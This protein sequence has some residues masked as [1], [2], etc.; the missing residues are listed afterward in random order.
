VISEGELGCSPG[1]ATRPLPRDGGVENDLVAVLDA[2]VVVL[3]QNTFSA[4]DKKKNS[5]ISY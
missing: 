2:A 3:L 4:L 1:G 5:K